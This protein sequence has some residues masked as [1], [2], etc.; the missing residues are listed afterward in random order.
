MCIRDRI[1]T[2]QNQ[3]ESQSKEIENKCLATVDKQKMCIRD[4]PIVHANVFI[5]S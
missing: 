1:S 2:V 4:R 5:K 3:I